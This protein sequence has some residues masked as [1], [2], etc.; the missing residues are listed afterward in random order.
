[1]HAPNIRPPM[2]FNL[3]DISQPTHAEPEEAPAKC[4]RDALADTRLTDT[5]WANEADDLA[6]D[7]PA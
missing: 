3:R 1:M 2:A 5:R 7:C 6:L 4:T